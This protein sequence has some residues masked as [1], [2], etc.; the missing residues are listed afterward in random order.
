MSLEKS[1]FEPVHTS[2]R[3][4]WHSIM[5]VWMG[6][7]ICIPSLLEGG[8]KI[9][10]FSMG[11]VFWTSLVGYAILV[12]F[13][14]FQGSQAADLG[15]PTT[16]LAESSFGR[17]GGSMIV[18]SVIATS[19]IGWFGIQA[20]LTG[21][22]IAAILELR[23]INSSATFWTILTGTLMMLNAIVGYRSLEFLNKIAV[24]ALL[25]LCS[26]AVFSAYQSF[27][28]ATKAPV[29]D[30]FKFDISMVD[31]LWGIDF[32]VGGLIVGVCISADYF[33]FAKNRRSVA[34]AGAVGVI[35]AGVALAMVG[36]ILALATGTSDLTVIMGSLGYPSL[37]LIILILA[38]WTTNVG[39]AY[40][41][42]LALTRMFGLPSHKR[43][44]ATF[45]AGALGT[46]LALAGI[47][48]KFVDFLLFLTNGV[49][50]VIGVMVCDYW[51]LSQGNNEKWRIHKGWH[52]PGVIAW[53]V[54]FASNY[55][56][57]WGSASINSVFIAGLLYYAI[58]KLTPLPK[59]G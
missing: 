22:A 27:D 24:P 15:L 7:M 47:L 2:R 40:S 52:I 19:L 46:A 29:A 21:D 9:L 41:S 14:Y 4:A 57:P 54:G 20:A 8:S 42:G 33:R 51:I 3:V 58:A 25:L 23:G 53:A 55:I 31:F 48:D 28:L 26:Y 45:V 59:K 32:T 1:A 36:A 30:F 11:G 17:K 39:N 35:P 43:H 37:A 49:T 18:S 16:V 13:M 6:M 5:I 44:W 12:V 10:R 50:P 38:S 56:I 34:L